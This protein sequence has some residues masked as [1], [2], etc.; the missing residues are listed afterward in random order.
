MIT[1]MR[2]MCG[3]DDYLLTTML[4]PSLPCGTRK[5]RGRGRSV[6][7]RHDY[8]RTNENFVCE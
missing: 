5:C 3:G 8:V 4:M 1:V 7:L 6:G 2:E